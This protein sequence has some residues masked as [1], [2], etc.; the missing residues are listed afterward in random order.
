LTPGVFPTH[1]AMAGATPP[2]GSSAASLRSGASTATSTDG[3]S[4]L[5]SALSTV[6]LRDGNKIWGDASYA[7]ADA[8]RWVVIFPHYLDSTRKRREGRKI[9]AGIAVERPN[10][11]EI[12][13][14]VRVLGLR[15]QLE[16]DKSY[17]R[18][19][20]VPGRVRIELVDKNGSPLKPDVAANRMCHLHRTLCVHLE[21]VCDSLSEAQGAFARCRR[22]G[23]DFVLPC[24]SLSLSFCVA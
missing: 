11:T 13:D 9:S 12:F 21:Y 18:D 8:S 20:W 24:L 22:D 14:S 17:C 23:A 3:A 10:A 4:A 19:C 5:G 1:R 15:T 16:L 6:P 7:D 2:P